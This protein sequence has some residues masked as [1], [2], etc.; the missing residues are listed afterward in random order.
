MSDNQG[1]VTERTIQ[2][3]LMAW[4]M[5]EKGHEFVIP[6]SNS[7][8]PWEADLLSVT[9]ARLVHEYE[10]KL[11]AADYKRDTAKARKH[12]TLATTAG[13]GP[14]YFWYVTWGFEIDPPDYAGW[15]QV[16]ARE[17][18]IIVR[19]AA[20]RLAGRQIDERQVADIARLLSWRL[21]NHYHRQLIGR[22]ARRF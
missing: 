21:T 14:H 13:V 19:K 12:L 1:A 20:P 8:L 17:L 15:L 3:T 5:G 11:N 2:A 22:A 6:N 18:G 4:A 16:E 9:R 7:L 10:I